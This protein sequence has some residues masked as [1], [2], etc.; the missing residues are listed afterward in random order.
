M[1]KMLPSFKN[2]LK[3]DR[4][5]LRSFYILFILGILLV[6]GWGIFGKSPYFFQN[7]KMALGPSPEVNAPA[8]SLPENE[9]KEP[10]EEN[11]GGNED[12]DEDEDEEDTHDTQSAWT[13]LRTALPP[14]YYHRSGQT[15]TPSVVLILTGLGLNKAWTDRVLTTLNKKCTLVFSPYSP[16]ISDQLQH[17]I[18]LGHQAFIA[19]PMEPY[20]FPNPDPGPLTLLTGAKEEENIE[21]TREVLKRTPK[22]TGVMGEYGSRFTASK[23]DLEPILREIKKQGRNFIDPNSSLHSQT[24][25][26]C[27][28]LGMPCHKVDLPTPLTASS[29]ETDEFLKKIIQSAKENGIII[30]SVPTIPLVINHLLE[31][32]DALEKNGINFVTIADL[33][34]PALSLDNIKEYEGTTDANEQNSHQPR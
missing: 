6:L 30:V 23:S 27:M 3:K 26:L 7:K 5:T 9:V 33:K 15:K 14:R 17:A 19:L 1:N 21:K 12:P 25:P 22:G 20:H 32:V 4:Q 31:W 11:E 28:A 2:L 34:T 10:E 13:L 24:Q 18:K 16:N 8:P 29:L